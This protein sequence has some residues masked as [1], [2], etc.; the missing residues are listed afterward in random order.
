[1]TAHVRH[2]VLPALVFVLAGCG[3]LGGGAD[4]TAVEVAGR[5]EFTEL[6]L[7]PVSDAVSDLDLRDDLLP[8]DMTLL[9]REDGTAQL[10]RLQTGE[11]VARGS[12]TLAGDRL[13]LR[14][15]RGLPD[16]FFP[17]EVEFEAGGERLSAEVPFDAVDLG[18][19]SDDF[20]GVDRADVVAHIRLREIG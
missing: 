7:D 2:T 5:Y 14:L 10:E 16:V 18:D 6:R 13:R 8:D 4:L 20:E 1:M 3:V 9:I 15:D 11:V 19:I 17:A 12:Y